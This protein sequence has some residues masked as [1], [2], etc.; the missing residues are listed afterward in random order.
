MLDRI[1]DRGTRIR[2]NRVFA[3][4]RKFFNWCISRD[5]IATSPCVGVK[6]PAE[7]R[8]RDRVLSAE[9]LRLVWLAT[10]RQDWPF[11]PFVKLLLLTAQRLNE[12]A[13][14]RWS[15][16]DLDAAMWTLPAERAKNDKA[17][18]VPLSV[19]AIALIRSLPRLDGTDFVFTTT[20][21]TPISGFGR[22]KQRLDETVQTI[23]R[24]EAE[25]A[26]ESFDKAA[27]F[28]EW[29]FH[30][31]RRTAVTG[32]AEMGIAPHVADRILN[33][34]QG[35]IRGVAAVYNRHAY[36]DER[37]KALQDWPITSNGSSGVKPAKLKAMAW[38]RESGRRPDVGPL[39]R[40]G[41]MI[42]LRYRLR[43]AGAP[44]RHGA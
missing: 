20:G 25:V 31:F 10:E 39:P 1:V 35:T 33:H 29:R 40:S 22:A 34:V 9:E 26:G 23:R 16:L 27:A 36:L 2:A 19:Q 6:P 32:M 28:P 12:V 15:E 11:G 3:Y 8:S 43:R 24:E 37:R 30:D 41:L 5:L 18:H 38:T 4:T 7:E 13:G 21:R 44:A 14:M 17:H 42:Y